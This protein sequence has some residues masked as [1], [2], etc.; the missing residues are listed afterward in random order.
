MALPVLGVMVFEPVF[1]PLHFALMDGNSHVDFVLLIA[2]CGIGIE[3]NQQ[4]PVKS[5]NYRGNRTIT[6]A[7]TEPLA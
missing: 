5:T 2:I 1:H 6:G 3:N 7:S 4:S